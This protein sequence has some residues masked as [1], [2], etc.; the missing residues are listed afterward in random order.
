MT[1][2]ELHK[3][4]SE[5]PLP[6]QEE[7]EAR[8]WQTV[9]AAFAEQVKERTLEG[10][11]S[12]RRRSGRFSHPWNSGRRR[13]AALLVALAA[14][15][16]VITPA[17]AQV[18][19]W[20]GDAI[21][22]HSIESA[23]VLN[24]PPGG[25]RLL[26]DAPS[27]TW[28][29][30]LDGSSRLLGDFEDP[31]WS[32]QGLYVAAI[33]DQQLVALEPDGDVRWSLTRP[34]NLSSPS[35]NAP[36]GFRIAYLEGTDLRVV[37]GDGT[38]D[39]RLARGA[40]RVKPAWRPGPEHMVAFATQGGGAEVRGA[41][42]GGRRFVVETGSMVEGLQWS[43][44]GSRLLVWTAKQVTLFDSTGKR[45]WR[46]RTR[47]R[48]P[49]RSAAIEPGGP[50]RIAV[51]QGRE[52]TAVALVGPGVSRRVLLAAPGI[53]EGPVWSPD[54]GWLS[55][56]WPEAD[57]WIYLHG[58]KLGQV[59]VVAE[60]GEQFSPGATSPVAFPRIAG[61]CCD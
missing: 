15:I 43:A 47:S 59:D 37:A 29:T 26:V 53:L 16:V 30:D 57:Q 6:E 46:Y 40:A 42:D 24:S 50:L 55:L 45:I 41:D 9:R 12:P 23:K 60:V 3:R 52:R 4:L 21:D 61:W 49:V 25:G 8:A 19:D 38:G 17:G 54:G 36:D 44:D 22:G 13:V 39:Q 28:V 11:A 14:A 5:L 51:L 10:S 48:G 31:T 32:P 35:W 56:G 7:A 58:R 1:D 20:V 33:D 27:G 34:G 18:R 2:D